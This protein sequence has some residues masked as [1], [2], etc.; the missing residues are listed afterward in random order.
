M[1]R[2]L[3]SSVL[4]ADLIQEPL[5]GLREMLA[6]PA[7]DLGEPE[8]IVG[9]ANP[10]SWGNEI[11]QPC[12]LRAEGVIAVAGNRASAVPQV[13]WSHEVAVQR[14]KSIKGFPETKTGLS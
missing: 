2:R 6:S 3:E 14:V 5:R 4:Q 11:R 13:I 10:A 12:Y 9:L 1:A 7:I 8:G